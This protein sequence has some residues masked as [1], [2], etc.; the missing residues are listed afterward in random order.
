MNNLKD[1]F[2]NNAL[3]TYITAGDC[4]IETTK[5]SLIALKNAGSDIVVL[6]IPFSDPVAECDY[7]QKSNQRGLNSKTFVNDI[8]KMLS[9]IKE[10]NIP[11]VLYTYTNPLF[12]YG[13]EK[14]FKE[15]NK[16]D[17]KGI[18]FADLPYEEHREIKEYAE[19]YDIDII[20]IVNLLSKERVQTVTKNAAGFVGLFP[21]KDDK[22]AIEQVIMDIKEINNIPIA[23]NVDFISDKHI[24]NADGIMISV[25]IAQLLEE[26]K[27]NAPKEIY[28]YVS[29]V[30]ETQ[31]LKKQI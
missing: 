3:I 16:L 29:E 18:M 15:C 28:D 25:R 23:V 21:Q 14:F 5:N 20:P 22:I 1:K 4:N 6:G 26:Y 24:K 11:I 17:V 30:K 7:I 13:Y 19:K 9:S 10:E 27:E 8:F 12:K 31:L 2:N